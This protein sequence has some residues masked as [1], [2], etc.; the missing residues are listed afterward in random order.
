MDVGNLPSLQPVATGP[1]FSFIKADICDAAALRD[2]FARAWARSRHAPRG[3]SAAIRKRPLAGAGPPAPECP[4]ARR[5]LALDG[6][7]RVRYM[8]LAAP[9]GA[10]RL[11]IVNDYRRFR[12]VS[13]A[14]KSIAG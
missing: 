7:K 10:L 5:S 4:D 6:A 12:L 3:V 11:D 14:R 2:A 9:S 1:R 13:L 8:F